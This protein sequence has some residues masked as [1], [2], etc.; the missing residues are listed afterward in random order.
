MKRNTTE[1]M[2]INIK[3][4]SSTRK[5]QIPDGITERQTGIESKRKGNYG[6]KSAEH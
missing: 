2:K 6:G 5:K 3:G 1:I 4:G